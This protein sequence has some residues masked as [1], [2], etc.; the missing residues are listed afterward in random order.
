[1]WRSVCIAPFH[2]LTFTSKKLTAQLEVSYV[3]FKLKW[4]LL[5]SLK[6]EWASLLHESILK[7]CRQ[8]SGAKGLAFKKFQIPE[9]QLLTNSWLLRKSIHEDA[10][11]R[12]CKLRVNSCLRFLSFYLAI[13]FEK[14][15]FQNKI[16]H[17]YH[18]FSRHLWWIP[19]IEFFSKCF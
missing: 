7:I 13:K 5:S 4:N 3:N 12:R 1:M 2:K 17:S 8:Y 10:S 11:I 15:I 16:C 9:F 14:G 19:F 6:N 18:I